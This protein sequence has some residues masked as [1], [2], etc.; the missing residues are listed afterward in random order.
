MRHVSIILGGLLVLCGA[1]ARAGAPPRPARLGL[2]AACHGRHGIAVLPG[3][4]NLAAQRYDYLLDA[5]HQY[6]DGRREVAAMR[7]ALGPLSEADLQ[8]LAHWYAAQ[9]PVRPA[10]VAGPG[11][12]R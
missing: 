10:A 7:A 5:M 3:V 4:P 12:A 6:R 11:G 2:C 9:K 8:A 1:A